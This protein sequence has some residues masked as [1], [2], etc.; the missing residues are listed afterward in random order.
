VPASIVVS[1]SLSACLPAVS[2]SPCACE[3]L[4]LLLLLLLLLFLLLFLVSL[5]IISRF[6]ADFSLPPSQGRQRSL[7]APQYLVRLARTC[8]RHCFIL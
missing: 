4:H 8:R 5:A 3:R 7:F 2:L 1:F 6:L